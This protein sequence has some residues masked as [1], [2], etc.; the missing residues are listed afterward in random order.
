MMSLQTLSLKKWIVYKTSFSRDLKKCE[1][2]SLPLVKDAIVNIENAQSLKN[3]LNLKSL[4]DILLH[5]V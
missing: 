2:A 3:I 5:I 1:G 4:K